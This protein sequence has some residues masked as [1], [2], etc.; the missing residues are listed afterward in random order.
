M[1]RNAGVRVGMDALGEGIGSMPTARMTSSMDAHT[2]D[3]SD[4][5]VRPLGNVND[6]Q[7]ADDILTRAFMQP[8]R[9]LQDASVRAA[10]VQ[11][12]SLFGPEGC[13]LPIR[14]ANVGCAMQ[15]LFREQRPQ[16]KRRFDRKS[17]ALPLDV[18]KPHGGTSTRR[19]SLPKQL[20]PAG[21]APDVELIRRS[22]K[23]IQPNG[24]PA[25]RYRQY[26]LGVVGAKTTKSPSAGAVVYNVLPG[27]VSTRATPSLRHND[28]T[29]RSLCS[30]SCSTAN[31][32]G[33]AN[34][35]MCGTPSTTIAT[36]PPDRPI[37]TTLNPLQHP[38]HVGSS[39]DGTTHAVGAW[40]TPDT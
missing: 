28:D 32:S 40:W 23:V 21:G 24:L 9:V 36:G 7:L 17:S 6:V 35:S 14:P 1:D 18:W 15:A 34:Q 39:A 19:L 38:E 25:L 2:R 11:V 29:G 22:G 20:Q 8:D 12:L 4:A 10:V 27:L 30:E 26:E 31:T 16:P 13:G 5:G 3:A 33:V 37:S